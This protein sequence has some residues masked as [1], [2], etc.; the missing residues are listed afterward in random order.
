MKKF[1]TGICI[2]AVAASTVTYALGTYFAYE[3]DFKIMLNGAEFK[4]NDVAVTINDR[5]YLPLRAIGEALNVPVNWNEEKYQVEIDNQSAAAANQTV[6]TDSN[7]YS[8]SNPAPL[9]TMQTYTKKGTDGY[10]ANIKILET[11]RGDEALKKLREVSKYNEDP[12]DGYEYILVKAA[13]SVLSVHNDG[14]FDTSNYYFKTFSNNNEEMPS[15]YYLTVPEPK[16]SGSMLYAGG[17]KEGWF[18]VQVKKDDPAPKIAYG[19]DYN[20]QDGIW[21]SLQ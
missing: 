17:N 12:T 7:Q 16:F 21:F 15:N 18:T 1:I 3:A 11:I 14:A 2:G 19:L 4:S 8:R 6:A 5:T 20:G 9:N 13:L 10:S